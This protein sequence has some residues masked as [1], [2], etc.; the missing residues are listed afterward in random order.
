MT[1]LQQ[2]KSYLLKDRSG[3]IDKVTVLE[4]TQKCYHLQWRN[5]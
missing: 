5:H 1:E 2:G 3:S 4:V